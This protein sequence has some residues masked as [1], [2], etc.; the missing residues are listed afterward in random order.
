MSKLTCIRAVFPVFSA[1]ALLVAGVGQAD[2]T[3]NVG[4]T[5]A[6]R[7]ASVTGEVLA[8]RSPQRVVA[9]GDELCVG[10]LITTGAGGSVGILHGSVLTQ[11]GENSRA[12][13]ALTPAGTPDVVLLDGTVRM[14]DAG[15]DGAAGRLAA[16]GAKADVR[17]NDAEARVAGGAV[18]ICSHGGPLKV[19][20]ATVD[21]GSCASIGSEPLR[22]AANRVDAPALQVLG[23][24][25]DPGPVIAPIAHIAPMPA[26][27]AP[28]TVFGAAPLPNPPGGPFRTC[29]FTGCGLGITVQAQPPGNAPF[30]GAGP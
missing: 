20:G 23:G 21:P 18:E 19:N 22:V 25:C 17:R 10:D 3:R 15:P 16:L 9:C 11:I 12:K 14:I 13:L 24:S 4:C 6:G 8:S 2:P 29:A 1:A 26:V 27:A 28:P 30:P 5:P 7:V